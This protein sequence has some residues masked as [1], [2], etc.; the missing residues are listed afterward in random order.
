VK[1]FLW[2]LNVEQYLAEHPTEVACRN[3]HKPWLISMYQRLAN[4][5][6]RLFSQSG[7]CGLSN[8]S[9][10]MSM[11]KKLSMILFC[12]TY[13]LECTPETWQELY[14][15][16]NQAIYEDSLESGIYEY[17]EH[18]LLKLV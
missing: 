13:G 14:R 5:T 15:A 10:L 9:E 11:D 16:E 12:L 1:V 8:I 4:D 18:L 3:C 2:D 7:S 17:E 6:K